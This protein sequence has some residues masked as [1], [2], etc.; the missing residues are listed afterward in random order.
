MFSCFDRDKTFPFFVHVKEGSGKPEA[1]Q[2]RRIEF[3]S[4]TVRFSGREVNCVGTK[5]KRKQN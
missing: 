3:V 2:L 1:S 5:H 4:F